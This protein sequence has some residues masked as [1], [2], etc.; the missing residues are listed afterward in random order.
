MSRTIVCFYI[1]C[2]GGDS[3]SQDFASK[4]NT[5]TN[6]VTEA[7]LYIEA[8]FAAIFA[9]CFL[10]PRFAPSKYSNCFAGVSLAHSAL[11][12]VASERFVLLSFIWFSHLVKK[13]G[14][15]PWYRAMLHG[16]SDRRRHLIGLRG[17]IW[18]DGLELNQRP[19][20]YEYPALPLSY[21]RKY[22]GASERN[23]TLD[24]SVISRL[25][26]H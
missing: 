25:L 17:I 21:H 11:R 23:R 26:D 24:L 13:L 5:S 12:V 4:A 3:N 20:H 1:W 22:T 8:S 6:C 18:F 19:R 2:L 16:F 15:S 9:R 7:Y 14:T 10:A